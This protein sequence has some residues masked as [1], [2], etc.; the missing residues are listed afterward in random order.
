MKKIIFKITGAAACMAA[1]LV[2]V[3]LT[4]NESSKDINLT[5]ISIATDANAECDTSNPILFNGN[6]SDLT[7]NCYALK[8]PYNCDS[9]R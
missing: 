3:S 6:C 2:N 5:G 7:G 9:S 8:D 1:L 4:K